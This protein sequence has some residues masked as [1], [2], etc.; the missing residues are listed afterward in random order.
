[1]VDVLLVEDDRWLGEMYQAGLVRA[2]LSCLMVHSAQEAVTT[3]DAVSVRCVVLDM[4]LPNHNG[5]E[6][7]HEL[8]SYS[9]WQSL[10]VLVLSTIKQSQFGMDGRQWQQYGVVDYLYKPQTKPA[11]LACTVEKFLKKI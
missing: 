8:Q 3:L 5:I 2:G 7:L 9:D 1:M 4:M 10:P 11:Q 6:V